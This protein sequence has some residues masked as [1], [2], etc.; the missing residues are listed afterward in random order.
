MTKSYFGL[1]ISEFK[2]K[3]C[4]FLKHKKKVAALENLSSC[5]GF[6]NWNYIQLLKQC[7]QSGFLEQEEEKFLDHMLNKNFQEFE[8]LAWT[9]KTKWLKATMADLSSRFSQPAEKQLYMPLD[10][11]DRV[12]EGKMPISAII[13]SKGQRTGVRA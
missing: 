11:L 9:H 8:Y 6:A 7:L 12:P 10:E 5:K 3:F 4:G 1:K 13:A 2:E